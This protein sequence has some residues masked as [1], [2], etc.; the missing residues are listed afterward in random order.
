MLE[1]NSSHPTP[2]RTALWTTVALCA[3][4]ANS[5]LCRAALGANAS[6]VRAIDAAGFT[7]LRL[8]SGAIVLAL[9]VRARG[10][11]IG[12]GSWRG[13][14]ALCA[15][16]VGFSLAYVRIA[17]GTG[18]LILFGAVQ[19]T[20]IASAL[21][22]R[23]HLSARQWSGLALALAGLVW[24]VLPGVHAP[25]AVG[26]LWMTGAGIAWGAY[27]LMGRGSTRPLAATAHNFAW[28]LPLAA[29]FVLVERSGLHANARGVV[30]AVA[31]GAVASGLGYAVWY[32]ALRGLGAARAAI[33][34]LAVPILA[35]TGGVL[36]LAEAPSL[37]LAASAAL[38]LAGVAAAVWTRPR[39]RG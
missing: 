34:Q 35:A 1:S 2:A 15:Y 22:R 14:L 11:R 13:G 18:A 30:L 9:L 4:A 12:G 24:L 39:P 20:M 28:S 19:V 17:A 31:S 32:T 8:A 37:R 26:A 38:V 27:S 23:E 7:G 16:A 21:A 3:F 5:L 6:D 25:D 36:F 10:E 29:C 33:V